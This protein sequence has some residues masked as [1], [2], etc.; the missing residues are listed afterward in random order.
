MSG[1]DK[2]M[3]IVGDQAKKIVHIEIREFG[4]DET[5]GTTNRREGDRG[6][7]LI[8]PKVFKEYSLDQIEQIAFHEVAHT[9]EWK[10]TTYEKWEN[11][12]TML[13]EWRSKDGAPLPM[14]TTSRVL[15]ETFD[16]QGVSYNYSG[17]H[18]I[19]II[20]GE[21]GMVALGISDYAVSGADRG[22]QDSELIA[23]AI[24]Y[25]TNYPNGKNKVA[26]A[27]ASRYL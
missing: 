20:S 2:G 27:V 10:F 21:D 11:E 14:S 13:L 16:E 4:D 26:T 6:V 25:K 12:Q 9:A 1:I 17:V 23:E 8:S 24:R 15:A 7:V 18:G 3:Q 19:I 22:T 5:L